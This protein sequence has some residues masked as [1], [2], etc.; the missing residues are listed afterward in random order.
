MSDVLMIAMLVAS[1][2]VFAGYVAC[3]DRIIGRT[4]RDV[5]ER[6]DLSRRTDL[7]EV[8]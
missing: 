7:E 6:A 5:T 3:C 1:I 8:A 2:M 4:D